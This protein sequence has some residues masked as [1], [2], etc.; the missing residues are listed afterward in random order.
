LRVLIEYI[1][2]QWVIISVVSPPRQRDH[3]MNRSIEDIAR[4]ASVIKNEVREI[5]KGIGV[6]GE[7][8][9]CLKVY[10]LNSILMYTASRLRKGKEVDVN[11]YVLGVRKLLNR[12]D[13]IE[14]ENR[15][16]W[17]VCG[18]RIR[19]LENIHHGCGNR[20][21]YQEVGKRMT[22]GCTSLNFGGN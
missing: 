21:R 1:T 9:L 19:L 4:L 13:R 6:E 11:K 12:K 20:N 14:V 17:N 18:E 16:A 3:D 5:V 10:V 7:S 2:E 15:E 22:M 8:A